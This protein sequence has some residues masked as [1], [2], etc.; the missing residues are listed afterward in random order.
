MI[1]HPQPSRL[2]AYAEGQLTAE[3][4][5]RIEV[6]LAGCR[7]CR[8]RVAHSQQLGRWLRRLSPETPTP[9]LVFRIQA[10][11]AR[12]RS[13]SRWRRPGWLALACAGLGGIL[14]FLALPEIGATLSNALTALEATSLSISFESLLGAPWEALTSLVSTGLTWQSALTESTSLILVL[15]VALLTVAA[16]GGLAQLLRQSTP[17]NGYF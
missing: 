5:R 13:P 9:D 14:I 17:K 1:D 11:V 8:D 3:A 15:G 7:E 4:H 10:V 6:H 12:Q 2:E 16:L